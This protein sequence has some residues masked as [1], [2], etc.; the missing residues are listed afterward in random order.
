M[1]V[2]MNM[3][4][5]NT[6]LLIGMLIPTSVAIVKGIKVSIEMIKYLQD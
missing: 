6:V 2:M 3:D 5:M 1:N 4:L